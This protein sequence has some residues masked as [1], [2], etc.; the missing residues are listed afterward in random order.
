MNKCSQGAPCRPRLRAG[1]MASRE[2]LPPRVTRALIE[3][4]GQPLSS[5]AVALE[6]RALRL[7]KGLRFLFVAGGS[8]R[9][10]G[11][12]RNEARSWSGTRSRVAC[13]APANVR[14]QPVRAAS[15]LVLPRPRSLARPPPRGASTG[16]ARRRS[17]HCDWNAAWCGAARRSPFFQLHTRPRRFMHPA[18]CCQLQTSSLRPPAL[19]PSLFPLAALARI[20]IESRP[21]LLRN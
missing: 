7:A 3:R 21:R 5:P 1:S 14:K 4:A 11:T 2:P 12:G 9:T 19:A 10:L 6:E 8:S 17:R 15:S 20:K 13:T 18:N 16:R